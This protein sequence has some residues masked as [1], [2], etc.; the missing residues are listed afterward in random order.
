MQKFLILITATT[1]LLAGC[2]H[3]AQWVPTKYAKV[4]LEQAGN[5]CSFEAEKAAPMMDLSANVFAQGAAQGD[6]FR[7]CMQA[8]GFKLE[9]IEQPQKA[10]R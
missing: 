1:V 2:A 7:K 6:I 10:I 4:D 9:K 3:R 5:E 8:K